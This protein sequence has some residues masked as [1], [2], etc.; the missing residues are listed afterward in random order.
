MPRDFDSPGHA[1]TVALNSHRES[2]FAARQ[3]GIRR[4]VTSTE[5]VLRD[6]GSSPPAPIR[7]A[8]AVAV[9]RNPWIGTPTDTDLH[10]ATKRV[11]P[12]VARL[13][14]D[15]LIEAL[16]G[17]DAIEA[18]GKSA[19]V[20]LDGE[21]EHAGALVH[22]PYFGNLVREFLDGTSII[23]F[24]DARSEAG[25][26]IR[27]PLWHKRQ[28]ATR[29]HYQTLDVQLPD[30]PHAHEIAIIAVAATGPR[31]HPRIGDRTTDT[32]VTSSIL[33][34]IIS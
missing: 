12:V 8:S 21:L 1:S 15:R 9:L 2:M 3:V 31:P 7:R 26:T 33:K 4:L 14:C 20:G 32:V 11:A 6:G 18:F 25:G 30:A 13:L 5:E 29:S 19:V 27:V 23:C 22:T 17:A 10:A 16:G 24:T 28:A 34:G